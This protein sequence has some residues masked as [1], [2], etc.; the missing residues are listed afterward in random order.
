MRQQPRDHAS[1]RTADGRSSRSCQGKSTSLLSTHLL[2]KDSGYIRTLIHVSSL[3][4]RVQS[5]I[6]TC[7]YCSENLGDSLLDYNLTNTTTR[8]ILR[9]RSDRRSI[10][11]RSSIPSKGLSPYKA[12]QATVRLRDRSLT[13]EAEKR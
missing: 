6:V 5:Y 7:V 13:L 3:V 9:Y 12:C 4:L 10:W 2:R 1:S 8:P 11:H